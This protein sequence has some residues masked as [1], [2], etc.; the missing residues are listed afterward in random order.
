[1]QSR[2][3]AALSLSGVLIAGSSAALVNT[4]VLRQS[5]LPAVAADAAIAVY[6]RPTVTV[7]DI[8][9]PVVDPATADRASVNAMVYDVAQAGRVVLDS[10]FGRLNVVSADP[11]EGWVVRGQH[12]ETP[13]HVH[14]EFMLGQTVVSFEANLLF[15]VVGT[16]VETWT[17]DD[18]PSGGDAADPPVSTVVGGPTTTVVDDDLLDGSAPSSTVELDDD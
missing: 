7:P 8:V 11:A 4:Q 2:L 12:Q 3:T 16:S 13:T 6:P 18:E 17:L 10:A 1:M 15:G 9:L 5:S 14:V